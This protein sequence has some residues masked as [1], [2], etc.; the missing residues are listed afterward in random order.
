[1]DT[2]KEK[3]NRIRI[4]LSLKVVVVLILVTVALTVTSV[5]VGIGR[6][7][8]TIYERYD[9]TAYQIAHIATGFFTDKEIKMYSGLL[10]RYKKGELS[11]EA[12]ERLINSDN[13]TEKKNLMEDLRNNMGANDIYFCVVDEEMLANYTPEGWETYEWSPISYIIDCY[14]DKENELRFGDTSRVVV[15]YKDVMADTLKTGKEP[16]VYIVTDTLF[17]VN[18]QALYAVRIDGQTYAM[19]GVEIPMSTLNSDLAAFVRNIIIASLIVLIIVIIIGAFLAIHY[20]VNP[21]KLIAHEANHF[22]SKEARVSDRLSRVKTRDEIQMLSESLLAMELSINDYIDDI[23]SI[24]AEKERIGAELNVATQIQAS[25]VPTDFDLY[26][27]IKEFDIYASMTPAKEVGGDFYDF[28]MTDLTHLVLVMADVSGKGVPAALF[29]AKG[30][31]AIKTR[32]SMGGTPGDILSDV[33]EMM[34]EGNEAELFVTVWLAI[35]DLETGKG[36][37]ANA[38]HEHPALR[39]KD[40]EFEMIKYRHGPAVATMEGIPFRDHEF[41]LKPGDT[42]Y[43]YT[44]GVTEAT[45]A[46]NE[47][48]GEERTLAA[49]NKNPDATPEELLKNIRSDIDK[50][51]GKAPQF[52]DITMLAVTYHGK[53]G[54]DE[55]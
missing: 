31:T 33:N 1:M 9:E 50:F 23:K 5:I 17:G 43:V 35:I 42:L 4:K 41:E 8:N 24:T 45:D 53:Q 46:N 52:D 28:F 38:G 29:M 20:I 30:K 32:A 13:Y 16:D 36:M 7:R 40:G 22:I 18:M 6:Y 48:F 11:E 2:K 54:T 34:V 26:S 12:V 37:A 47:L 25:M 21:V 49:L 55:G 39:H 27:G 14:H 3:D 44:D 19:M 51:V 15:E 10:G